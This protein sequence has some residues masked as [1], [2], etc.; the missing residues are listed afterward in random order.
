[1]LFVLDEHPDSINDALLA[2]NVPSNPTTWPPAAATWQDMPASYHNGACGFSFADGHGEIK[3]W[4]D[5]Q[6]KVPIQKKS[7]WMAGTGTGTGYGTTSIHDQPWMA[8]RSTAP[9]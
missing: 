1:M 2:V 3:K 4:I 9:N 5:G 6:S 7:G 8:Y